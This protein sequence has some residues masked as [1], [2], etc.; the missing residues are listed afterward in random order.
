M[1]NTRKLRSVKLVSRINLFKLII[2]NQTIELSNKCIDIRIHIYFFPAWKRTASFLLS[3]Q[4]HKK[5]GYQ[6]DI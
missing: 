5:R 4:E 6:N 2:K 1:L 3:M